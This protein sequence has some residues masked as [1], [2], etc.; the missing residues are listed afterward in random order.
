MTATVNSIA[1]TLQNETSFAHLSIVSYQI[2]DNDSDDDEEWD[3][4]WLMVCGQVSLLG[5]EWQFVDPCLTTA[6]A[7]RLADW[8]DA[9]ARGE[10]SPQFCDFTEPNLDFRRQPNGE[11]RVS[12]ALES[13][14]PWAKRG[15]DW[16]KHGFV[17]PIGPQLADAA[18]RLRQQLS[19]FP[20]RGRS[21]NRA[22]SAS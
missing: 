2:P 8:L 15:D 1:M 19:R 9:V 16:I 13:A 10:D 22:P 3:S 21:G 12:F 11:I 6:E 4:D 17:V 7:R 5:R 18:A 20:T 14:P